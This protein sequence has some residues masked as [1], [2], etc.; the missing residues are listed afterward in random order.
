MPCLDVHLAQPPTPFLLLI[1]GCLIL[2]AHA[3]PRQHLCVCA[4]VCAL[5]RV[6]LLTLSG[7]WWWICVESLKKVETPPALSRLALA[8][9][10]MARRRTYLHTH[11]F[12]KHASAQDERRSASKK[13]WSGEFRW[14]SNHILPDECTHREEVRTP[15]TTLCTCW[16]KNKTT[17]SSLG[18]FFFV[19]SIYLICTCTETRCLLLFLLLLSFHTFRLLFFS[20]GEQ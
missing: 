12:D 19:A 14:L 20:Q 5:S 10:G 2:S 4:C 15:G 16:G 6:G 18:F 3:L 7:H 13:E 11:A 8:S 9:A 17:T 1:A